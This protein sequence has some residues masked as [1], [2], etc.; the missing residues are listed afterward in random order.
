VQKHE[1]GRERWV[2]TIPPIGR[3]TNITTAM[4]AWKVFLHAFARIQQNVNCIQSPLEFGH[5]RDAIAE[6]VPIPV[7]DVLYYRYFYAPEGYLD[8]NFN[9]AL[10]VIR[11]GDTTGTPGCSG[12]TEATYRIVEV[13]PS[14]LG[15]EMAKGEEEANERPVGCSGDVALLAQKFAD[16]DVV[17]LFLEGLEYPTDELHPA[18]LLGANQVQDLVYATTK[19]L[20]DR[21]CPAESQSRAVCQKFDRSTT[22]TPMTSII[23]NGQRIE[24]PLGSTITYVL[25]LFRRPQVRDSITNVRIRRLFRGDYVDVRATGSTEDILKVPLF[26]GDKVSIK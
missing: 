10:R 7:T 26:P 21:E 9:M 13:T 12:M 6:H 5:L 14:H 11:V 22:V 17:R 23:V 16:A 4:T 20:M 15:L 1:R 25:S 2:L 18:I 24:V 19:V 8:L 3:S